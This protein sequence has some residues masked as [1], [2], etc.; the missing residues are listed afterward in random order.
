[1]NS[2]AIF[3]PCYGFDCLFAQVIDYHY[4]GRT[5]AAVSLFD[6]GSRYYV[7]TSFTFNMSACLMALWWVACS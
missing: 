1:M 3:I 7:S 6:K 5:L 2:D 4:Q